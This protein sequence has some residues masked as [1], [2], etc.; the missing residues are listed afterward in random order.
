MTT[1][2][3]FLDLDAAYLELRP[4]IDAAVGE[5]LASGRYLL[6]A[7]TEAF[8]TEF[9]AA[10]SAAHCVTVGSGCDA[11]ELSLTALGVGPGDEVV[12]PA[13]TFI[14]TWL[15]VSRCGARPVPVEPSPGSYLVDLEAVEAAITPRTAAILAV[16]LYGE[17]ADLT[18]LR[19]VADRHGLALVEDAAQSTGARGRDGAVVGSGSTAA[20]FSFYPGKNLGA[21]GDGGA[22]VTDDD[23]LARRVRLLRNYGSVAKYAHEVRGTNS[24]LDEIQAAVLRSKLPLL[25]A[26]NAR[27]SAIAALYLDRLE[28]ATGVRVPPHDQGDSAWHLFVIRCDDRTTLQ[29]ELTRH[30]VETLVHYPT[31]VH[32][33]PAYADH[34]YRPGSFPRAER[35]A[36]EVLSLPIGPHLAL[37]TAE[38][39]AELVAELAAQH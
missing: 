8:E 4:E 24:R 38:L 35:L 7:Q 13:H 12:V 39:V 30:G 19:R 15:A 27:R 2:V 11:L 1:S 10:C 34:G 14:A 23:E 28:E 33:S 3:P 31:P 22:V 20:A 29:G 17:V 21:L 9:A 5:V 25:D 18:A 26:W 16:H 37:P 6:G 32:L 36:D